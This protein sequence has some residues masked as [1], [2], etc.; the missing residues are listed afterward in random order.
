MGRSRRQQP[1]ADGRPGFAR[2]WGMFWIGWSILLVIGAAGTFVLLL[3]S[4]MASD[5]CHQGSTGYLCNGG[6]SLFAL[7]PAIGFAA[8]LGCSLLSAGLLAIV[9]PFGRRLVPS[10]GLVVGMAAWLLVPI[11][12]WELAKIGYHGP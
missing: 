6:D 7:L 2:G 11:A 3:P 12:V 1:T 9:R 8:A 10:W 5:G 4:G